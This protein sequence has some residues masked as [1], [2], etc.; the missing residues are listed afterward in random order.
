MAS[1]IGWAALEAA[2]MDKFP[3]AQPWLF[4]SWL[5]TNRRMLME[6]W[7]RCGGDL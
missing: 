7:Q 5:E 2:E 6:L 4:S 3:S 1:L